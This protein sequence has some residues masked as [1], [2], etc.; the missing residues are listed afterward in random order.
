[1]QFTF[2]TLDAVFKNL[3]N[4]QSSLNLKNTN[5]HIM[6]WNPKSDI[7]PTQFCLDSSL[8]GLK[9][10]CQPQRHIL[11]RLLWLFFVVVA[12]ITAFVFISN[13]WGQYFG[14]PIVTT[15]TPMQTTISEIPFPA[16]TICNVN[17]VQKYKAEQ[18]L[19]YEMNIIR[20]IFC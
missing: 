9:Y 15:F 4:R 2:P 8:H 10:W 14:N 1:M 3:Q 17:N 20:C 16:V 6:W 7:L 5:S 11:E 12:A 18:I 19:S 13:F